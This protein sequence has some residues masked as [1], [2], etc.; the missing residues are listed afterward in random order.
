MRK[1]GRFK[2]LGLAAVLIALLVAV[3]GLVISR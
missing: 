3:G 2:L 1:L